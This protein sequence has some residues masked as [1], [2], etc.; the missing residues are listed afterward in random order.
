MA[1]VKS[2]ED[3]IRIESDVEVC[4]L[5]V[6]DSMIDGVDPLENERRHIRHL[7]LHTVI[8]FDDVGSTIESL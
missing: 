8:K 4:K 3:L 7:V 1:E 6:Q 2:L 5:L